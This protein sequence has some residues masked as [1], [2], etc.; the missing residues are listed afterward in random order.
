MSNQIMIGIVKK[1]NKMYVLH[2]NKYFYI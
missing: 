2:I 1:H